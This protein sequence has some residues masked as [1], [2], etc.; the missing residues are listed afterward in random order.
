MSK[1]NKLINAGV[2]VYA[3][4]STSYMISPTV[5]YEYKGDSSEV[6]EIIKELQ[7]ANDDDRME[8]LRLALGVA[9]RY[10]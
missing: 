8:V 5:E 10:L 6:L 9:K 1:F 2:I 7:Q 3:R 4:V